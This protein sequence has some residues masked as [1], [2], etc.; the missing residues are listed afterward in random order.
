MAGLRCQRIGLEA[1]SS[2][3]ANVF[4][5]SSLS[6]SSTVCRLPA[7]MMVKEV[8]QGHLHIPACDT[9]PTVGRNALLECNPDCPSTLDERILVPKT[10]L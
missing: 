8:K 4:Q 6:S 3:H 9:A 2:I 7:M 5:R 1:A 10:I